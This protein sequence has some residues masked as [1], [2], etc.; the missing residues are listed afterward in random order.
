MR[1]QGEEVTQA[2]RDEIAREGLDPLIHTTRTRCNGR[3]DD[4]CVV[5]QYPQGI[6]YRAMTPEAGRRLV[7]DIAAGHARP[8]PGRI[9][10]TYREGFQPEVHTLPG[11]YKTAPVKGS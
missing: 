4:A 7:R 10:Y 9:T 5:I 8:V 6:W 3:C 11:T 1:K 2:I